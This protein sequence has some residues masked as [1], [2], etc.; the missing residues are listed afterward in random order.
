MRIV[1]IIAE[2]N[3]FHNGHQYHIEKSLELTGAD[4]AVVVMSGNFIQRGAPAIMPKHSRAKMALKNGA[5][6]VIELPVPYATGSAE[7][8]AYGAVSLLDDFGC[9]DALCFGSECGNLN[10]LKTLAKILVKEPAE[11]KEL[12]SCYLKQGNSFPL[13]RQYAMRDYLHSD[14]VNDILAEPNNILGIEYLKALYRLNSTIEPYT[15]QRVSSHYHDQELQESYSSASAIRNV[16]KS[17]DFD[18]LKLQLSEESFEFLM[19][20]V[21]H[22]K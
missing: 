13:A 20:K 2:Y 16:I 17:E 21:S 8:F 18:S 12:L 3:P 9:V 7:Y 6:L 14:Q 4:A 19:P 10:L 1:G 11:Y 22:D 5:S 15:I